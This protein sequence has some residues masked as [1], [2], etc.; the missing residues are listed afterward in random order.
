MD[1]NQIKSAAAGYSADMNRFL[2]AMISHPSESL[3]LIH[4]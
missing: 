4:I 2:R 3:S 1:F